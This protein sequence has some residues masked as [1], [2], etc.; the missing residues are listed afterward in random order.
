MIR[1]KGNMYV[2]MSK[3]GRKLGQ[4][5]SKSS[6]QTRIRQIEYFKGKGK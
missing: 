4:Y 2:I 1:K 6:S 5:S 3:T